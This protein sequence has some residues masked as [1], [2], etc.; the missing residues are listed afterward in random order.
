MLW[1]CWTRGQAVGAPK[2][3]ET[4]GRDGLKPERDHVH[5]ARATT[6]RLGDT[7][8]VPLGDTARAAETGPRGGNEEGL[9]REDPLTF[10]SR[11]FRP[12]LPD[13]GV[14]AV[15]PVDHSDNDD[16]EDEPDNVTEGDGV[17]GGRSSGTDDGGEDHRP[18]SRGT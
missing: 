10:L 11:T 18:T 12:S 2:S 15:Q 6:A 17:H 14:R 1:S 7:V 4:P 8:R 3:G 16:G 5:H 9:D 13:V